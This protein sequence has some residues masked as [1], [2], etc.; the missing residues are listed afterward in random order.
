MPITLNA[1]TAS[2]LVVT[3]DNS[4]A[5]QIQS[6]GTT[7]W[8]V[9]ANGYVTT[10]NQPFFYA[11]LTVQQTG[12]NAASTGD[13]VVIYNN[14]VQNI[15]SNYSTSTG[16]FT[17]PVDG[18]YAFYAGAYS[19]TTAFSQSWLVIN[20]VRGNGVDWHFGT[21]TNFTVGHWIIK[22]SANDTVGFHPYSAGGSS[23]NIDTNVQH[24]YFRGTLLG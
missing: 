2:G 16:K 22:L 15:G 10:P 8:Q 4:G 6:N 3:P 19:A 9:N 7:V 13:V 23:I 17:A 14:L 1:S 18:V 21:S 20:G 12:F 5:I 24:T 11:N